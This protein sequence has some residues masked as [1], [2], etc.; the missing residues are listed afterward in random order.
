MKAFESFKS[1][2]VVTGVLLSRQ[3]V[4]TVEQATA[5][6]LR[7]HGLTVNEFLMLAVL[8]DKADA[9]TRC[10]DLADALGLTTGGIT[11]L[12]QRAAVRGYVGRKGNND[13]RR[14]SLVWMTEFGRQR[15][16]A[17]TPKF[18]ELV[19]AHLDQDHDER[20]K[21]LTELVAA[22]APCSKCE[23]GRIPLGVLIPVAGIGAFLWGWFHSASAPNGATLLAILFAAAA[24]AVLTLSIRWCRRREEIAAA[25]TK[26]V[27]DRLIQDTSGDHIWDA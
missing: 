27:S 13:D 15:L 6:H 19:V 12:T 11:R 14:S 26:S 7:L 24:L 5:R 23:Q 21:T 25:N 8:A 18:T 16:D 10:T 3:S 4:A 22:N 9:T 20:M 1:W 17:A 2:T